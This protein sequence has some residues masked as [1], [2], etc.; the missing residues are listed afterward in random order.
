[1]RFHKSISRKCLLFLVAYGIYILS[2]SLEYTALQYDFGRVLQLMRYA[3]Y[4]MLA[5]KVLIDANRE[6]RYLLLFVGLMVV[7]M[8]QSFISGLREVTF[9]FLIVYALYEVDIEDALKVQIA[10]QMICL[11]SVVLLAACGIVE[12]KEYIDHGTIRYTMGFDYINGAGSLFLSSEI[13]WLY[14]RQ[15]KF[16][17]GE[18]ILILAG[19]G[20]I[21]SCTDF[22]TMTILGCVGAIACYIIKYWKVPVNKGI[23]KWLYCMVPVLIAAFSWIM[24]VTYNVNADHKW[25][26]KMNYAFNGRLNLAKSAMDT[27]GVH[28]WGEKVKWIGNTANLSRNN[29]NFVDCSYIK[30]AIDYGWVIALLI[31]VLYC[32]LFYCMIKK[33]NHAGCIWLT[34]FMIGAYMLPILTGVYYNPLLLLAGGMFHGKT[35]VCQT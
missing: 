29:Y 13:A 24:Q 19:W 2:V 4:G 22:R 30:V 14:I 21:Y 32:Y 20:L 11:I 34:L 17:I 25:M 5:L 33:N 3:A 35:K 26:Q 6:K 23:L 15:K 18:L 28:L 10:V 31:I 9:L 8:L 12:N 27:Y 7:T 1:M 16:R